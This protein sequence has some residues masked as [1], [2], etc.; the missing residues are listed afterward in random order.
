MKACIAFL[1][2]AVLLGGCGA[3]GMGRSPDMGALMKESME[4]Q[5]EMLDGQ[6][7]MMAKQKLMTDMMSNPDL[8]QWHE[9]REK[10]A[11]ALG[12]RQF[13]KGFDRVFDS[14]IIALA[15]LGCRVQN[16][17]RVSGYITSSIPELPPAQ[18]Q[19][20]QKEGTKQYAVAKGYPADIL[21]RKNGMFDIDFDPN[22]MMSRQMSG[23]TLTM[24]KQGAQATKVKLR[25]DNVYYPALTDEYYR[26]VWQAVDKQMFLDKGLD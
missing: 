18:L 25:F 15:T 12:D 19:A 24:V 5:H 22:S 20:L 6:E 3:V 23:L 8:P 1:C 14:M 10:M 11:L 2:A 7:G 4:R 16:M 26:I 17:E 13:D 9:Q 21:D